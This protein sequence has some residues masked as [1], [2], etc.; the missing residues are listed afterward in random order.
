VIN[1]VIGHELGVDMDYFFKVAHCSV[2]R[3]RVGHDRMVIEGVNERH[4]LPGELFT[5]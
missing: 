2:H 3:F 5:Y 1:A 4:H